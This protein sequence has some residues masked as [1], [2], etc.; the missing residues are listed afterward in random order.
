MLHIYNQFPISESTL[1]QTSAG[2]TILFTDNAVYALQQS[3]TAR[4]LIHNTLKHINLCASKADLLMR[5]IALKDI[6]K[7]VAIIDD[8]E[9]VLLTDDNPAVK[10]W[11]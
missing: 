6:F 10:S 11:N 4:R 9:P 8:V 2:D 3:E 5:N 1:T 7:E